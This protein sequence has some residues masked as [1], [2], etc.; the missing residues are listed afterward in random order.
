MDGEA[1]GNQKIFVL[2][3]DLDIAR[4]V[5][6]NLEAAGFRVRSFSSTANVISDAQKERPSLMLLDIMVPGGDGLD[7]CRQV[8]QSGAPLAGTPIVF[9]TAKT[10]E[11][12]RILGLELGADDYITKP[13]S[14][15]ELVARIR[16]VLRRCEAP[17]APA[18]IKAGELEIDANAMTLNVRGQTVTTTSTEFRLLHYLAQHSG[19]VF[20]RDQILDAVWR[21]TTFVSPRSVDVYVRK[22][23][24]KIE[25]DA[26]HPRYLKT[27]RGTGYR[28]EVPKTE[29]E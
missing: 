12:D 22:L 25:R 28:F 10:S 14:P 7:L 8:R 18:S 1:A 21:E 16:A 3:D 13:F 15:R 5:R 23:R 2:E 17:L 20:T 4:L 11:T 6:H 26:E 9:L 27:V 29:M 24:E 19:R